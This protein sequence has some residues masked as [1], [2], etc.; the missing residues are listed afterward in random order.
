MDRAR[1]AYGYET[2]VEFERDRGRE[3]ESPRLDPGDLLDTSVAERRGDGG[4]SAPQ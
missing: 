3:N 1:L 4:S 2:D